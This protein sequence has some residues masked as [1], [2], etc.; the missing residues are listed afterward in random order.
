MRI[1]T[2]NKEFV[3]IELP[4]NLEQYVFQELNFV[5]SRMPAFPSVLKRYQT[6]LASQVRQGVVEFDSDGVKDFFRILDAWRNRDIRMERE[7]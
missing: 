4:E 7:D 3:T 6:I 1:F 5:H 2:E